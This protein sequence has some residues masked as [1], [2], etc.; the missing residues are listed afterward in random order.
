M[1]T[2]DKIIAERPDFKLGKRYLSELIALMT[3]DFLERGGKITVLRPA[4]AVGCETPSN[5][6]HLIRRG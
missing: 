5:V 6:R 2:E 1:Q 3:L 4:F